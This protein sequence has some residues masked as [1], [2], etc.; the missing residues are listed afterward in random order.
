MLYLVSHLFS[1]REITITSD[2]LEVF[3]TFDNTSN[4]VA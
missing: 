4:M 1:V 3:A 2:S